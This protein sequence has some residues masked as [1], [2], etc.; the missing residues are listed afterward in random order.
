[1]ETNEVEVVDALDQLIMSLKWEEEYTKEYQR[2]VVIDAIKF[3][4]ASWQKGD[5]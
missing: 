1:M 4:Y 2:R 3:V 5:L